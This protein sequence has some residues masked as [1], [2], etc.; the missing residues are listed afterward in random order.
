MAPLPPGSALCLW[1]ACVWL[2][3]L[4][5][6]RIAEKDGQVTSRRTRHWGH[7]KKKQYKQKAITYE[8]NSVRRTSGS[9]KS[10]E[11]RNLFDGGGTG[12]CT[13]TVSSPVRAGRED[14][15]E[16]SAMVLGRKPFGSLKPA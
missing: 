14:E 1:L 13:S 3:V 11:A 8:L 16:L 10:E 9:R 4:F 2:R 15:P 12:L 5:T 6:G 7:R